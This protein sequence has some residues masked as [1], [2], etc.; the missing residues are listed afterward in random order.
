MNSFIQAQLVYTV[1]ICSPVRNIISVGLIY[2]MPVRLSD[3]KI[4]NK[5]E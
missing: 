5:N 4:K 2:D 1:I 3:L